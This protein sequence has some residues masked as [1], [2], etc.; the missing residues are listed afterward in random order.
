MLLFFSPKKKKIKHILLRLLVDFFS[1]LSKSSKKNKTISLNES[2]Q[3]K[4]KV[5]YKESTTDK[6]RSAAYCSQL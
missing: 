2:T 1:I 3:K 6:A 5:T 4:K